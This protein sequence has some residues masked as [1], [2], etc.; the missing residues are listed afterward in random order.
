MQSIARV[1]QPVA[2]TSFIK[3]LQRPL[4]ADLKL[5]RQQHNYPADFAP[6][7]LVSHKLPDL[8]H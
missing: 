3:N 4:G 5:P 7:Y 8:L 2:H 1:V 6:K